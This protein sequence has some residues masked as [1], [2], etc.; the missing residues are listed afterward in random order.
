MS[1][2]SASPLTMQGTTF[3]H[4]GSHPRTSWTQASSSSFRTASNYTRLALPVANPAKYEI[5]Q[6]GIFK[7]TYGAH[8]IEIAALSFEEDHKVIVMK[9]MTVN[10]IYASC[11]LAK[12]FPLT[13][14]ICRALFLE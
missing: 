13:L 14:I 8:G 2:Y 4:N 12:R 6:P 3:T 1:T 10:Q 9:K 5:V 11:K 7:G